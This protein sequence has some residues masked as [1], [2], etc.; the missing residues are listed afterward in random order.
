MAL[1]AMNPWIAILSVFV[2]YLIG[3]ISFSRVIVR[4]FAPQI[5]PQKITVKDDITGV[6]H[7]RPVNASTISMALNWKAGC[8]ISALDMLKI[9]IPTLA[10]KLLFPG[11][12]YF[13]LA[14]VAGLVGNNWPVYYHFKG[15]SGISAIYGGLLV[16]D[17][18][19]ILVSTSAGFLIGLVVMRS[20][21]LMFIL[22]LL[23][24]IPWLWFR[25]HDL[26]YLIYAIAVN[27]IYLI[28]FIRDAKE[29]L[30]PGVRIMSEKEI[31][32]QMP[33]G[34]GMMRMIERLGLN[35]DS[36]LSNRLRNIG[37]QKKE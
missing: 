34:R 19:A 15:G 2:T 21:A 9:T 16:I 32:S 22:S 8:L 23:L 1:I 4:L 37:Q 26:A 17:P 35:M 33:M 27:L 36:G 29:Y 5:D 3:S 10:L 25:F 12:M 6:E 7:P 30:R 20:F 11:Q 14:A 28:P 24:I 13:L 31:M 18:F